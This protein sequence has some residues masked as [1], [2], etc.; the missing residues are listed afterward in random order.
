MLAL[1]VFFPYLWSSHVLTFFTLHIISS[2]CISLYVS[3]ILTQSYSLFQ[4]KSK[5]DTQKGQLGLGISNLKLLVFP[6]PTLHCTILAC[7]CLLPLCL[8]HMCLASAACVLPPLT[9]LSVWEQVYYSLALPCQLGLIGGWPLNYITL[10][11]PS[12]SHT[13]ITKY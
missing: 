11:P 9:C 10:Q 8:T 6:S 5:S 2:L 4:S 3:P 1:H 12:V 13:T 7:L